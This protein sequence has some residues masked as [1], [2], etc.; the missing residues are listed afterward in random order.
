MFTPNKRT[1]NITNLMVAII[2]TAHQTG[3]KVV[4]NC[5]LGLEIEAASKRGDDF[6]TRDHGDLD[7][8]PMEEDIPFWKSWFA[9]KKY[10]VR[11]NEEIKDLAKA[12][13]AFPST[14]NEA[15]WDTDPDSYYVDVYGIT[16]DQKG[17][18]GSRVTGEEIWGTWDENFIE[19]LWGGRKIT[20]MRHEKVLENKCK[21]A[22]RFGTPLREKDIHDYNLF[23]VDLG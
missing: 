12:F 22:K 10:A 15:L 19:C 20:V 23:G 2:D 3:K 21:T 14:Y 16:V 7:I 18:V 8:H 9:D 1:E 17:I 13:V 6:L 5:G 11:G 4:I